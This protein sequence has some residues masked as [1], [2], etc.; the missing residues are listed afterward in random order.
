MIEKK[1]KRWLDIA[2][3]II[4]I[5]IEGVNYRLKVYIY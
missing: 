4:I 2:P 1:K 5:V 3:R